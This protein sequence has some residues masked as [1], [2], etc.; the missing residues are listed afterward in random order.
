MKV[1]ICGMRDPLNIRQVAALKP[2]WMGFIFYPPS[3][4]FLSSAQEMP[5]DVLDDILLT[6]VFVDE[7]PDK[8]R[9]KVREFRLKAVQLHG[10]ESPEQCQAFRDEGLTVLKALS[11]AG[12]QDFE[13]AK[14]YQGFTDLLVLDTKTHTY[15]GSGRQFDWNLLQEYNAGS[16]FLLSGG[17]SFDD[18]HRILE[19]KHPLL[20]GVDLNSRFEDAPG[21]KNANLLHSFI[22]QLR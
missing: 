2:D 22:D 19:L 5:W 14:N 20:M 8:I 17:I 7:Q 4:R 1:K 13:A 18:L 10:K 16:P 9:E 11:I 15:G 6:G 3:P 21:L 12:K